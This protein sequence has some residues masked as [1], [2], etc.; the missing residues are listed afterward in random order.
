VADV[1]IDLPGGDLDREL[2]SGLHLVVP[3]G[4]DGI[5][6][7]GETGAGVVSVVQDSPTAIAGFLRGA[8]PRRV[9]LNADAVGQPVLVVVA[10]REC[11]PSSCELFVRIGASDSA[12]AWGSMLGDNQ[13][14]G[15]RPV[16]ALGVE[17]E[18]DPA[19]LLLQQQ[20]QANALRERLQAERDG[21]AARLVDLENALR[22]VG[23]VGAIVRVAARTTTPEVSRQLGRVYRIGVRVARR[24]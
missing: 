8:D 3:V 16:L 4:T 23:G 21:L 24:S 20:D 5:A 12:G 17:A 22:G 6:A 18:V 1:V 2:G 9:A 13:R 19:L 14:S 10:L 15:L 7:L 11:L